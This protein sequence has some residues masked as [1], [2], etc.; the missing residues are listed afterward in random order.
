MPENHEKQPN[1]TSETLERTIDDLAIDQ[2]R[3]VVARQEFSTDKAAAE[4]IEISPDTVKRWKREGVPID[5]VVRLMV[6]DGLVVAMHM[7]RRNL[8]KAM[9]VKIAGLDGS[10]DALRQRVATEI[11][12]WEMG[13][14]M[15]KIAPT[16]PT[17][18]KEYSG[19]SNEERVKRIEALLAIGE[20]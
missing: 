16:D 2:I 17:G 19:F 11:I 9:L 10:D 5:E 4:S 13:K 8:A 18:E 14:A 15:Q 1:V 12:E 6:A 3:F 7:R 20:K